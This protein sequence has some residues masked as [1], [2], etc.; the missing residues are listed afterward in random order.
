MI[1]IIIPAFN[2]H[3][4]IEDTLNSIA[5]QV[6]REYVKVTVVNDNGNNYNDIVAS[7]K[8]KLDIKELHK[9]VNG[10]AGLARQHGLDNTKNPFVVFID[11]DDILPDIFT[12]HQQFSYMM[13]N[14]KCIMVSGNF[15]EETP[16]NT[17]VIKQQDTTWMHG[18]MYRR[19]HIDKHHIHFSDLRLCEDVEFN[20]RV[21]LHASKDEHVHYLQDRFYYIWKNNRKS[22][23]REDVDKFPYYDIV[24]AGTEASYRALKGTYENVRQQR[25]EIMNKVMEM[26]NYYVL[27][28]T[29][30]P[31]KIEWLSDLLTAWQRYWKDLA[32]D[33]YDN[34]PTAEIA[35]LFLNRSKGNVEHIVPNITLK[36][37]IGILEND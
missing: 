22:V 9:R 2:A 10:G 13:S 8:K 31:D 16:N 24:L 6:A 20:T 32:K 15:L 29:E 30:K 36:Q 5:L 23:T 3:D 12:L 27:L 4:T 19:S 11:A 1:D 17:Y 18:K 33:V 34:A 26:F 25:G 7:F 14:E 35:N 28:T 21:K 37:F